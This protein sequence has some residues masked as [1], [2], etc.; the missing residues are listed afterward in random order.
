MTRS[1]RAAAFGKVAR[2][3]AEPPGPPPPAHPRPVKYTLLMNPGA[4][5]AL[6]EDVA[7]ARQLG[8]GTINK[9]DVIRE[10]LG[11]L[12]EDAT[13]LADVVARL[14]ARPPRI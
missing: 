4:A 1:D 11:L 2:S 7:Q 10:L 9:S 12:H 14:R 3:R 8:A 13:L 6:D 5:Q